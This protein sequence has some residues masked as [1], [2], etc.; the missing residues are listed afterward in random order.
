[1]AACAPKTGNAPTTFY[2]D[3]GGPAVAATPAP[4]TPPAPAPVV[5]TGTIARAHLVAVL[6]A[7][8]GAFLRQLEVT[9]R[10]DGDR[11]ELYRPLTVDPMQARHRRHALQGRRIVSRH[12]PQPR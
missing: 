2:E 10:L 5:R 6:D 11:L 9:A 3:L 7:G 1:M 8:P 4:V 12:R